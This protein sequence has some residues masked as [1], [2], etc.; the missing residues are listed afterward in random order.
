M[1]IFPLIVRAIRALVCDH[2]PAPPPA[3]PPFPTEAEI[4]TK[5]SSIA[6]ELGLTDNN[7]KESI[8]DLL[9]VLGIPNMFHSRGL[10]Y[11]ELGGEGEYK[12]SAA[13]NTWMIQQVRHRF[14]AGLI[15]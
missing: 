4:D 14:A 2:Q 5:L 3:P 1:I 7:F 8:T 6:K 10:L 15:D 12:G 13:Q 11:N 9:V